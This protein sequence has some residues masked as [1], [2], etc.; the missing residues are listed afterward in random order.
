MANPRTGL[1]E[2]PGQSARRMPK[3]NA[4]GVPSATNGPFG[5]MNVTTPR[6]SPAQQPRQQPGQQTQLPG[7]VGNTDQLRH[8]KAQMRRSAGRKAHRRPAARTIETITGA[9]PARDPR[10]QNKNAPD[11]P[12][13]S[14]LD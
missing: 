14:T 6:L 7:M 2:F 5:P 13:H 12:G 4:E 3:G 8:T 9:D 1:G 11:K 10:R